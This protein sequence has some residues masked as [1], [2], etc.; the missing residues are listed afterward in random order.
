MYFQNTTK[1]NFKKFAL[2]GHNIISNIITKIIDAL[3]KYFAI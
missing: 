3:C 2:N 1:L